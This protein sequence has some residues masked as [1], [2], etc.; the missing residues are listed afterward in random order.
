MTQPIRQVSAAIISVI[1]TK[2]TMI[3]AWEEDTRAVYGAGL[4]M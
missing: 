1:V 4:L 2:D 3:H